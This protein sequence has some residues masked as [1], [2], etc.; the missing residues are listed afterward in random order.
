MK[1]ILFLSAT[2]M[3]PSFAS[4][5]DAVAG[6]DGGHG[7]YV[8]GGLLISNGGERVDYTGS[9]GFK[10]VE[11]ND[12]RTHVGGA[13]LF[14][15]QYLLGGEHPICIGFEL[16]SDFSPRQET[17]APSRTSGTAQRFYDMTTSTNGFSPFAAL[18]IGYV[19]QKHRLMPYLKVGVSYA[20]SRETYVEYDYN[21]AI[22]QN[23]ALGF[24]SWMPTVALGVEKAVAKDVT[25][26]LECE[27]RFAKTKTKT[28]SAGGNIKCIRKGTINIRLLGTYNV[29]I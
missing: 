22:Q 3:L 17:V 25:G 27:Y 15:Y 9:N 19:H 13:L 12:F 20:K 14:G 1:K 28:F 8:G 16:G 21:Y 6:T 2:L 11:I 4:A 18:R 23:S 5:D 29:K 7:F 24:A 10:H 26:R